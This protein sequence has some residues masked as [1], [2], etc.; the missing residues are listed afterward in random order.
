VTYLNTIVLSEI[1]VFK[2]K[3]KSHQQIFLSAKSSE[4]I[5]E[6]AYSWL[7]DLNHISADIIIQNR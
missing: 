5:P 2:K 1:K 4:M 7:A 3:F 6:L